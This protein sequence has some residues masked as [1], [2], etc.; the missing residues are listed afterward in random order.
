MPWDLACPTCRSVLTPIDQ[1]TKTCAR[2][3]C[4]YRCEGQIWRLLS[5]TREEAFRDFVRQYETVRAAEGRHVR[6]PSHLRA[7]PFRDLSG[8]R[9][10]EWRVR[11]QSFRSLIGQVVRPL[12]QRSVGPLRILDLG[13]GLGWLAYRLSSRGHEVAAVDLLL[14]DF[15]GLGAH[16]HFAGKFASVQAEFDRLPF[17]DGGVDLVIYNAA[18]HYAANYELTLREAFRVL[19]PW[20]LVVI[21]DTP[22]YR[23]PSSGAAMVREREDAFEARYGF[24]GSKTEGFLTFDRLQGL[25]SQLGL[26]W[27]FVRPWYGLRWALKPGLARLRGTREPAR[28]MLVVGRLR[29]PNH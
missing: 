25:R 6:E 27:E 10:Y 15:D 23:D 22:I 2:C 3:G 8:R 18:F 13:S 28:F 4:E 9:R 14:N 7:L 21:M 20:G 29:R 26:G 24:R 12:E 16:R 1:F 17:C 11:A 5:R 19:V